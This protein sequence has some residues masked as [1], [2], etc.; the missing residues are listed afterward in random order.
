M[1]EPIKLF[2]YGTLKKGYSN[3]RALEGAKF[4]GNCKT[5]PLY[6]M[7]DF[8]GFPGV[9]PKGN[10]AITGEMY[11]VSHQQMKRIDLIEGYPVF[12]T[13]VP[14]RTGAYGT[15]LMYMLSPQWAARN[16]NNE[17]RPIETGCWEP[18]THNYS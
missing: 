7:I 12:Y 18:T 10:T 2:V 6:R 1:L 3:H 4:I 17:Y 8:G 16:E 13:R 11:L 14:I 9:L 15:A 5:L